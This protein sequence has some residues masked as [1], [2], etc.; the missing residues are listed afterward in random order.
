M[1]FWPQIFT[2]G[3]R[4]KKNFFA[5]FVNKNLCFICVSSVAK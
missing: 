4:M 2:D 3:T 5:N 1:I